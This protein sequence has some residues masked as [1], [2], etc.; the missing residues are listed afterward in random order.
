MRAVGHA[1]VQ[2]AVEPVL[3][4]EDR[5]K[6]HA[7][8]LGQQTHVAPALGIHTGLIRH[9]PHHPALELRPV[10]DLENVESCPGLDAGCHVDA[11]GGVGLRLALAVLRHGIGSEKPGAHDG[12]HPS[13]QLDD[14]ALTRRMDAVR[15]DDD[16][17]PGRRIHPDGRARETRVADRAHRKE[18]AQRA[19]VAR[20]HIPAQPARGFAHLVWG[21]HGMDGGAGEVSPPAL[22]AVAEQHPAEAP[23]VIRGREETG[24]PRDA[25]ELTGA[26]IVD[27]TAQHLPLDELGGRDA[28]MPPCRRVE[29]GYP[30]AEWLVEALL[31]KAIERL[32]AH[33]VH[34]LGEHDEARVAVAE[35]GR[36]RGL[37]YARGKHSHAVG[38]SLGH[39]FAGRN[40]GETRCMGQD[41]PHGQPR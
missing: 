12:A 33:P 39:D 20:R 34:Q 28:Q 3:G 6:P 7:L 38:Q 35:G 41:P 2:H 17:G 19:R 36:R 15:Q 18:R 25:V 26:R 8:G 23:E 24:V 11:R 1:R 4:R 32:A 29:S 40:V 13:A 14:G 5:L 16:V 21:E 31:R 22:H 27:H 37:R 30:H 9:Q 10:L